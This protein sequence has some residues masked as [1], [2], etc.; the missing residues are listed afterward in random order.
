MLPLRLC[1]MNRAAKNRGPALILNHKMV[2]C[3]Y[4]NNLGNNVLEVWQSQTEHNC[5]GI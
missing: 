4:T 5:I 3:M 2:L 1:Y